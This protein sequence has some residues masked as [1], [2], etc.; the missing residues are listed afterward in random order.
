MH[1][2]IDQAPC[3]RPLNLTDE[4]RKNLN[5]FRNQLQRIAKER[6]LTRER[7]D[8]LFEVDLEAGVLAW[9]VSRGRA[10]A[11]TVAGRLRADGYRE[12]QI[13]GDHHKLHRLL[14]FYANDWWP[15]HIHHKNGVP[16]DDRIANLDASDPHHNNQY[17]KKQSNNTSGY[18][19]VGWNKRAC[20]WRAI[21]SEYGKDKYLGCFDTAEDAYSAYREYCLAHGRSLPPECEEKYFAATNHYAVAGN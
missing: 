6:K 9:K 5:R 10:K 19:G 3:P 2:Y 4:Q 16:G 18:V 11:G 8:E 20:K 13:D 1:Q 12:V 7:I 17:R 14:Y 21:A 15:E